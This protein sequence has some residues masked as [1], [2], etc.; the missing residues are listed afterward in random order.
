MSRELCCSLEAARASDLVVMGKAHLVL[1]GHALHNA[2]EHVRLVGS[3]VAPASVLQLEWKLPGGLEVAVEAHQ[4]EPRHVER[5]LHARLLLE[6]VAGVLQHEIAQVGD[7]L[8]AAELQQHLTDLGGRSLVCVAK[9]SHD[10]GQASRGVGG[11]GL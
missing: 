3:G 7:P 11:G 8:V 2:E 10:S 1:L 6:L 5:Q 4:L 9:L